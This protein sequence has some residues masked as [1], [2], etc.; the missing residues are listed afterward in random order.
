MPPNFSD[1]IKIFNALNIKI[2]VEF[3]QIWLFATIVQTA[4][5]YKNHSTNLFLKPE[6]DSNFE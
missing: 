1:S 5:Y 3:N 6:L 4:F 2:L